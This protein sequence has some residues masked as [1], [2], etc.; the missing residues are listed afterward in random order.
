MTL[1]KLFRIIDLQVNSLARGGNPTL[2]L[3]VIKKAK[4][5]YEA[6]LQIPP[7]EDPLS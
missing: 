2:A 3:S 7:E 5:A 4:I 1:A 6:S